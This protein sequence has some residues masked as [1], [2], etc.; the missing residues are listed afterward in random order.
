MQHHEAREVCCGQCQ[1]GYLSRPKVEYPESAETQSAQP[2]PV[3]REL[4]NC[5]L[6]SRTETYVYPHRDIGEQRRSLKW[7]AQIQHRLR[8]NDG[9]IRGMA[10]HP[11]IGDEKQAREQ[12]G[13]N[14]GPKEALADPVA[15]LN[16]PRRE[17]AR[18]CGSMNLVLP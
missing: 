8:H 10:L 12:S 6:Q 16:G 2:Q 1:S 7:N 14:C 4:P 3:N 9:R 5:P 15:E 13:R 17:E 18:R 11:E